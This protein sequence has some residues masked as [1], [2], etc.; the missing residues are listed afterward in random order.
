[1]SHVT[2][3]LSVTGVAPRLYRHLAYTY[4]TILVQV[5]LLLFLALAVRII[6]FLSAYFLPRC[7]LCGLNLDRRYGSSPA[8]IIPIMADWEN[9]ER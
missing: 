6:N 9:I 4:P 7:R 2:D 5:L 3:G 1:M 8:L